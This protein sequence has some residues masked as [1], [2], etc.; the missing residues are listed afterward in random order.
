MTKITIED[1]YNYKGYKSKWEEYDGYISR[2]FTTEPGDALVSAEG[3][4]LGLCK[5]LCTKGRLMK[6]QCVECKQEFAGIPEESYDFSC[7]CSN[8]FTNL[9]D[10][11]T[12]LPSGMYARRNEDGF[13][14]Y[15]VSKEEEHLAAFNIVGDTKTKIYDLCQTTHF[16]YGRN[17]SNK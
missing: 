9:N 11:I 1:V 13:V 14:F 6:Y 16:R 12:N 15:E 17:L 10:A 8:C 3:T 2:F 4:L 7:L 5:N